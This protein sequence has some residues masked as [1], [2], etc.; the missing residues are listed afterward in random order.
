MSGILCLWQYLQYHCFPNSCQQMQ[1][2]ILQ[3][4][5]ACPAERVSFEEGLPLVDFGYESFSHW[6]DTC[7]YVR[8]SLHEH[9]SVFLYISSICCIKYIQYTFNWHARIVNCIQFMPQTP[10]L[11]LYYLSTLISME[12]GLVPMWKITWLWGRKQRPNHQTTWV[13]F[14]P[15]KFITCQCLFGWFQL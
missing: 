2:V 7:E 5:G 14:F 4:C 12:K 8:V 15:V 3:T 13:T 9:F 1:N 10:K 6:Q 11:P